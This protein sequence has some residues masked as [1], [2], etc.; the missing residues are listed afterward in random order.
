METTALGFG[1]RGVGFCGV[2]GLRAVVKF[3][4]CRGVRKAGATA[5]VIKF[6]G[7]MGMSVCN[8]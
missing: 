2:L 7:C 6:R 3:G 8:A 1:C 5:N 4:G